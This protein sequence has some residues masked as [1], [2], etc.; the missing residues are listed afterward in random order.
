MKGFIGDLKNEKIVPPNRLT[1][2]QSLLVASH[3]S[4]L[5]RWGEAKE[6]YEKA[7]R[8]AEAFKEGPVVAGVQG[9]LADAAIF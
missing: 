5:F 4:Q 3:A 7:L 2:V 6:Y 1:A 9:L 8:R